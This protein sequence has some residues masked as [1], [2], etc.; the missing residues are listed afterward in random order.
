LPL[1]SAFSKDHSRVVP[2]NLSHLDA[3]KLCTSVELLDTAVFRK[4]HCFVPHAAKRYCKRHSIFAGSTHE[5]V[6]EHDMD[7]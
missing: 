6:F 4:W 2:L 5:H 1:R 7:K 3:Q